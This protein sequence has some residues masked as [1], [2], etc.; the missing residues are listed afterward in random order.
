[1]HDPLTALGVLVLFQLSW[2]VF[3][4]AICH[5]IDRPKKVLHG[6]VGRAAAR[7]SLV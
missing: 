6:I 2:F 5:Q 1:M 7:S 4:A 3:A